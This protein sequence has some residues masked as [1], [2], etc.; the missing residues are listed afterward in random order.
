MTERPVKL[1][2][3]F[4]KRLQKKPASMQVAIKECISRL[5]TNARHPGLNVHRVQG[6]RGVWEAYI[7]SGNRLTFEYEGDTI[8]LLNHCNHDMLRR[9]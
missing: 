4:S 6:S 1:T 7:D 5:V 2:P 9:Y 3:A 8:V